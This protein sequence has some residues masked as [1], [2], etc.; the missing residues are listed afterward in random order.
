MGGVIQAAQAAMINIIAGVPRAALPARG[1]QV[2]G[3]S[4][5]TKA[6]HDNG[7]RIAECEE[8]LKRQRARI[9]ELEKRL[10]P[11]ANGSDGSTLE[12]ADVDADGNHLRTPPP[13]EATCPDSGFPTMT[14]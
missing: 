13:V 14:I 9:E 3:T 1:E 7:G 10:S 5:S 11:R 8:L 12:A 2:S 4:W 6:S